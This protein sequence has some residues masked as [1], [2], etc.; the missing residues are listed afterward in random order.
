MTLREQLIRDER[1]AVKPYTDTVGKITIGVGRNLTDKGLSLAE[2]ELLLDH[3]IADVE[4]DLQDHLPWAG[5]LDDA[6]Q[7]VLKNMCFNLG[8][9]GLL[10]FHRML[11][12]LQ[13]G[14]YLTAA[15]EMRTSKWA[16]QVGARA[17]RLA[18][19]MESGLWV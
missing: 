19:Q 5:S 17:E 14:D 18:R 2:V 7:G 1:R 15:K 10:G 4:L 12:A 16:E 6:R 3:D 8:L 13:A 9:A 11:V